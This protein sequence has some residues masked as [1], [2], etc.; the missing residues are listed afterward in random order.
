[1]NMHISNANNQVHEL[2]PPT[3]PEPTSPFP[4]ATHRRRRH[5]LPRSRRAPAGCDRSSGGPPP[6]T[7]R[8]PQPV[9]PRRPPCV[10]LLPPSEPCHSP[11]PFTATR[12][13]VPLTLVTLLPNWPLHKLPLAVVR[14]LGPFSG[15]GRGRIVPAA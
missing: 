9:G 14:L 10:Q 15:L 2:A 8:C 3:S 4:L 12:R 11:P 7:S 6:P 5:L 13:R 1:M